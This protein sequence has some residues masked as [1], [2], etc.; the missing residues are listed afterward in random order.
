MA[1]VERPGLCAQ[2]DRPL[3]DQQGPGRIR[4]YCG[5]TCR[6]AARRVRRDAGPSSFGVNMGLTVSGRQS[7]V[8]NVRDGGTLLAD[9][10]DAIGQAQHIARRAEEGLA[11]AVQRAREAGHTWA[12]I[13]QVLGTSR[14]AAFQRFGRPADPRTGKPMVPSLPDVGG[15]PAMT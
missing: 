3:P 15:P 6:S 2:C 9:P 7:I 12:A 10:L 13:G 1:N 11:G 8:D 14:Q 5:A 4:R